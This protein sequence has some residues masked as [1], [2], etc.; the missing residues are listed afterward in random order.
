[1]K[2]QTNRSMEC[3][4]SEMSDIYKSADPGKGAKAINKTVFSTNDARTGHALTHTQKYIWTYLIL[5]TKI[6]LKMEHSPKCK[7]TK[8]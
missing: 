1:M 8:L 6:K 3:K 7:I 5:F 4:N 2:E